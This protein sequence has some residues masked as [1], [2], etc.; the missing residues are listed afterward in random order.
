M[1][2]RRGVSMR[3]GSLRLSVVVPAYEEEAGIAASLHTIAEATRSTGLPFE[4]IVV[5][6]GSR[7]G[8]WD[9]IATAQRETPEIIAVRLS[10]NFGKEGAIAAGI[11]QASGDACI[12]LDSDLQHPPALIPEMVRLWRD[13]EWDVVDG[14]KS[15]RGHERRSHR[16]LTRTF[17]RLASRLTG[18]ELQ[19]ASDFK[20]LDRRVVDEWRRLGERVTFFRGLVSWLGFRRTQVLFA[21]PLRQA[22]AS[23][24]SLRSLTSLA[25]HAVTSFSALPLQIVTVLGLLTLLVGA[26]LGV[27]ALRLWYNG[28]A[29]PGFTTVILLELIIGGFLMVSL[30]IIG[31]YIARIYDEVK[32]R[33]R[34]IIRESRGN[35]PA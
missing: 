26:G 24:W 17:Y 27:Q 16:F 1:E 11:D 20:L 13:E 18:H 12:V 29:L 21:V 33:P 5:D 9:A 2:N 10:R 34:Y 3:S 19:D 28:D 32:G 31:V 22:G 23:R 15:D 35:R 6:D 30:G 4:L 14:V 7:D 8:T 25:V